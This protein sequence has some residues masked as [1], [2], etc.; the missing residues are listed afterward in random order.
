MR[1]P[2]PRSARNRMRLAHRAA[3]GRRSCQPRGP[4]PLPAERPLTGPAP[5]ERAVHRRM[6]AVG[7]YRMALPLIFQPRATAG[8]EAT[9]HIDVA[10]TDPF[11][12][13]IADGGY[14]EPA[15][16]RPADCLVSADPVTA[17]LVQAGR[18]SQWPAVALGRLRFSGPRSELG[19]RFTDL[20]L[21]P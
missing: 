5:A 12:V 1:F 10:G 18:L 6:S 17:L 16:P 15:A 19:P 2:L 14:E 21:I 9:Y 3:A 20:F 7:A 4:S 13:R 11:F 8:L